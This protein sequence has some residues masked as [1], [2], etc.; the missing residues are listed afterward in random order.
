[1]ARSMPL[2]TSFFFVIGLAGIG[3]PAS[4]GFAAEHL[5]VIGAFK[6]HIGVGLAT[7]LAAILGAAYFLRFFKVAFLGHM[8]RRGVKEASD[9]RP[10]EAWIATPLVLLVLAGGLF[11]QALLNYSKKP[12]QAWIARLETGNAMTLARTGA[13]SSET[14]ATAPS[15]NPD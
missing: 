1:M 4:N 3:V 9:L 11:P 10:R 15:T 6:A 8:E 2:L 12:L 5:I 14:H 13:N 7:L